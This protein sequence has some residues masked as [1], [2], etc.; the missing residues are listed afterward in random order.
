[1]KKADNFDAKQWLVENKI[2]FQSRLNEKVN[3]GWDD[4]NW[5][6]H[7][8]GIDYKGKIK[9]I[10]DVA[11]NYPLVDIEL[12]RIGESPNY[13]DNEIKRASKADYTKFPIVAVELEKEGKDSVGVLDGNHRVFQARKDGETKLK[14]YLI[15]LKDIEEYIIKK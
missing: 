14:G 2:T 8:N 12:S 1:M 13:D 3:E 15:P 9:D 6:L 5:L 7:N 4:E 10:V 11:K